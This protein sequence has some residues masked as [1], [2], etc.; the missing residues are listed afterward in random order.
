MFSLV[1][2]GVC[3]TRGGAL[4]AIPS[5]IPGP[6]APQANFDAKDLA[7]Y[8]VLRGPFDSDATTA[9]FA[10]R[11][12]TV[13]TRLGAVAD[14]FY[15][16]RKAWD[17]DEARPLEDRT[18]AATLRDALA[19]L[20]PVAVKVGQTLSQRPDLV[21]VEACE[22]LKTLQTNNRPFADDEALAQIAREFGLASPA[23]VAP[24]V[25]PGSPDHPRAFEDHL[26]AAF[27]E[28]PAAVASLGQV[29]RARTHAG[30]DVAVKVQRPDALRTVAL[31]VSSFRVVW[32]LV[33]RW[34]SWNRRRAGGDAFDN[35]DLGDCIDTVASGIFDE[36][37][38]DLEA[39]NAKVFKDSLDFLGFVDVP[40]FL[41]DLSTRRV[42]TTEWIRGDHL[43]A[44]S[45]ADGAI[46]T[47]LAVEACTASLVLT[48]FV[49]ADPHEGNLMLDENGKVVF[50]DFGLMSR[51]DPDIMESF[52]SG[53]RACLSE[54][55]ATL[56][57]TFQR[58]GFLTTPLEY[59]E[60]AKAPYG[61]LGADGLEKFAVELE[62]AM[63]DVEGGSS[64]FGALAT[65][66]NDRLSKRWKM[67]T[68]P[69]CLLL[70]RTFLTLE[71]IAAAVDDDF[72]IYEMSLPWALRRSLAPS[73]REGVE[74]LRNSLLTADN[75]IKWDALLEAVAESDAKPEEP[76]SE[77]QPET[78]L[79][80]AFKAVVGSSGGAALRAAARDVD[81]VDLVAKLVSA[82]GR[83]LRRRAAFEVCGALDR[84]LTPAALATTAAAA[85]AEAAPVSLGGAIERGTSPA[86]RLLAARQDKWRRKMTAFL[87][88][89]HFKQQLRSGFRGAWTL[90]TLAY[91]S[92]RILAGGVRQFLAL[93]AQ[94]LL[95]RMTPG[96][97]FAT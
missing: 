23:C 85:P 74:T 9:F 46:M 70:I 14:V 1:L 88:K 38:Y 66:L 63:K 60:S 25:L 82:E 27:S 96:G 4:S 15:A 92:L 22:A 36:L 48:G 69:Y 52:A 68:P 39:V 71:G 34:W 90:G 59:R 7:T 81:A 33:E 93:N 31:D 72:N 83:V 58:V 20:G 57:A 13:A 62:A 94:R 24:N 8:E 51:V 2:A 41:P 77:I 3:A 6:G 17:A 87:I 29:Y 28:A 10:T 76:R 5:R 32:N 67:F 12:W 56:A 64:R 84:K 75:R 16:T 49:H 73:S 37:D 21:G 61:K 91:L 89:A 19:S 47:Q 44:L 50:L 40:T 65:V 11:P 95:E 42:L 18:R 80:E 79:G 35:G 97:N 53:I 86:S 26:F 54:D 30:V 78:D 43:S 55:Y 45:K